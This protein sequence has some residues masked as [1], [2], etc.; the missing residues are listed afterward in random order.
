MSTSTI[1]SIRNLSI[2]FKNEISEQLAVNN[3]NLDMKRSQTT[4]IVGESGSGKSVTAYAMMQLIQPPGKI[5]SGEIIFSPAQQDSFDILQ[6]NDNSPALYDLRGGL[7]SMIFQEP[8]TALSPVHT[9][10]NQIMEAILTH[11]AIQKKA[12]FDL[13]A[14]ML[15]RVGIQNSRERMLQY[16]FE[17]SGGMRQR[18]MI[19]MAL[20][21][22]PQILICDEPTTALDVTIQAEILALLK[23]LKATI[24][25]SVLFITHDLAVV[26]QIAD[27]VIVMNQGRILETGSV[28]QILND[29][30]HPY[31]QGLIAAV[32]GMKRQPRLDAISN[33][34]TRH[35]YGVHPLIAIK[36]DREVALPMPLIPAEYQL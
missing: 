17:F 16:P 34:S 25:I 10:G 13:A 11:Q 29:P 27:Q 35:N 2:S 21:C 36:G 30:I 33:D 7:M 19:A 28:R 22:Q 20:V 12:A 24:D 18:V 14:A 3:I 26:A 8:M 31:S 4:A 6:L 5:T 23:E 32:P 15:E 9:I 1:L